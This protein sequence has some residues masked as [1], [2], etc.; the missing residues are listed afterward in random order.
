[1]NL[2]LGKGKRSEIASQNN[3]GI[4]HI[5]GQNFTGVVQIAANCGFAER[6]GCKW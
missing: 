6:L 4:V 5:V 1:M 2:F 3:T